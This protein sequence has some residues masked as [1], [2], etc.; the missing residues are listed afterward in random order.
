MDVHRIA[1]LIA[2]VKLQSDMLHFN[3]DLDVL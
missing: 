2:H 1:K 3:T